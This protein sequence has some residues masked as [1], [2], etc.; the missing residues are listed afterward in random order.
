MTYPTL[1]TLLYINRR[2]GTSG[3]GAGR[4]HQ[5]ILLHIV[6]AGQVKLTLLNPKVLQIFKSLI[7]KVSSPM[8]CISRRIKILQFFTEACS[9]VAQ[10]T[11]TISDSACCFPIFYIWALN[12]VIVES[13]MFIVYNGLEC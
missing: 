13:C 6:Y 2:V 1:R 5:L 7:I 9:I 12:A 11:A 4:R 8:D 10:V 3:L